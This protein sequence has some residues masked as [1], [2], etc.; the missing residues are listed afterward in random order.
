MR[1]ESEDEAA[2]I[3]DRA[4]LELGRGRNG[5]EEEVFGAVDIVEPDLFIDPARPWIIFEPENLLLAF[6]IVTW[7]GGLREGVGDFAA[8]VGVA[9]KGR[10]PTIGG[11]MINAPT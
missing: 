6:R 3:P 1:A 8:G 7:R 2:H 4:Q 11:L 9:G 10:P 5:L